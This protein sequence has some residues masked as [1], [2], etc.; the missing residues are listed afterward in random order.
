[1]RARALVVFALASGFLRTTIQ[2]QLQESGSALFA[3]TRDALLIYD[4]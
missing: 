3:V 2:K 1:M 4:G